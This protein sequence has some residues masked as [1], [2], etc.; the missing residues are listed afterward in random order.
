[1]L[2]TSCGRRH[3]QRERENAGKREV[4]LTLAYFLF[5]TLGEGAR[6][7]RTD[8]HHGRDRIAADTYYGRLSGFS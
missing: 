3:G 5:G 8:R 6:F 4:A 1:M 2:D 7:A